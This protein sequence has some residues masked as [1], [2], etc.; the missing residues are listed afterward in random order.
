MRILGLSLSPHDSS[1]A[2]VEGGLVVRAIEEEKLTRIRHCIRYDESQYDL[3]L[4]AAYF[5]T[6]FLNPLPSSVDA[7]IRM[8]EE[9]LASGDTSSHKGMDMIVGSNL[10][11]TEV[12]RKGSV[13]IDHHLAHA[14]HAFYTSPYSEAAVLVIDGAGDSLGTEFETVS[15]YSGKG[16]DVRLVQRVTGKIDHPTNTIIALS[17]SIGVL[18]QNASALCGFGPFGEGKLMGLASYGAPKYAEEYMRFCHMGEAHVEID[19]LGLYK[20]IKKM[21][22]ENRRE[23]S[24]IDIAA[25]VQEVV[26]RLVLFYV[27]RLQKITK[28]TN[29]CF[30]GGVALNATANSFVAEKAGFNRIYIPS[31]PGDSG[32]SIGAALYGYYAL[33]GNER[34]VLTDIPTP[35]MG[36][37]YSDA[38][39]QHVLDA[40]KGE[41]TFTKLSADTIAKTAADLL[42]ENKI[43]AWF[44]GPSEF[45]P[46][47]LGNRSLFASPLNKDNRDLLNKIK[48]REFFRPVA[49]VMQVESLDRYFLH[50]ANVEEDSLPYMLFTLPPL[51][52]KVA[53]I[54]P[55]V[56]HADGTAR[57]QTIS[58][59]QNPRLHQLLHEFAILSK[60]PVLIN[61][62][63]NTKGEPMV[64]T[65]ED[66]IETFLGSDIDYLIL[67]E[68]LIQR[69]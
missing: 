31:A 23:Q 15:L 20:H 45:G 29:L 61:T 8:L 69:K 22:E 13:N 40:H 56:I 60:V 10:L 46:R 3:D 5:D 24:L 58:K 65:P 27:Q 48:G 54:I 47:A 16:N 37:G 28:Q 18:Y 34:R 33:A 55:A 32:V 68:Y 59:N 39:V 43:V 25:S 66:A 42:M 11:G 26:N 51:N 38:E 6:N 30:A 44:Q 17:N 7:K 2:L 1:A 50:P 9:Y 67:H 14:A 63:F 4:D 19:N 36:K 21:T 41:L 35:Y 62:S 12:P 53:Q 57:L 64:E 52:E 49:P